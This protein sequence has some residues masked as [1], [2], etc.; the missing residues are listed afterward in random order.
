MSYRSRIPMIAAEMH[1]RVDEAIEVGTEKIARTARSRVP[2]ET[3][4]LKDAIHTDDGYVIAGDTDAFYGHMVEHGTTHTPPRPFLIPA[5][6]EN[7]AEVVAL[8]TAAL[9]GL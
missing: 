2:V 1:V 7:R 9:R 4:N 6:E 5:L 8:V 3:G